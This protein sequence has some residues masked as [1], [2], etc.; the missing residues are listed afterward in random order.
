MYLNIIYH[1]DEIENLSYR[2][3]K[4]SN[5]NNSRDLKNCK[6]IIRYCFSIYGS[7]VF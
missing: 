6:S 2:L 1:N 4:Y 7:A 3:I 5:S